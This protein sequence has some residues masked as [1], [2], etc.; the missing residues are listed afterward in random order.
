MPVRRFE[1]YKLGGLKT[2][3]SVVIGS[4]K[5]AGFSDVREVPCV[6]SDAPRSERGEHWLAS[7]L[8][9]DSIDDVDISLLHGYG[10]L[11]LPMLHGALL[12]VCVSVCVAGAVG[13]CCA[14]LAGNNE[15]LVYPKML[16]MIIRRQ[17]NMSCH[18]HL[19]AFA[20]LCAAFLSCS[21]VNVHLIT[22]ISGTHCLMKQIPYSGYITGLKQG[23]V[24]I[25]C[26]F[27][28]IV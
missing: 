9:A 14:L 8:E 26:H 27:T 5:R 7:V 22:P 17:S 16:G 19:V 24:S 15:G 21:A 6:S 18:F 23:T 4:L 10:G 2:T 28:P 11:C 25:A 13:V 12:I 20:V 3:P 1:Y